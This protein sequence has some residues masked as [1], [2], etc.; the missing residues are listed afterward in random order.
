MAIIRQRI[1]NP[2]LV[3]SNNSFFNP[4]NQNV[5]ATNIR[6]AMSKMAILGQ[7]RADLTDCPGNPSPVS[8]RCQAIN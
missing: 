5:M 8:R 4:D 3:Q 7:S 2:R 1:A 6:A